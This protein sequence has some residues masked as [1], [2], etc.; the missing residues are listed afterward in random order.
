MRILTGLYTQLYIVI[1]KNYLF[2]QSF[3]RVAMIEARNANIL[4]HKSYPSIRQIFLKMYV[5]G[6][7]KSVLFKNWTSHKYIKMLSGNY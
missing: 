3:V 5:D 6:Q 4:H 2:F 1:R 7:F